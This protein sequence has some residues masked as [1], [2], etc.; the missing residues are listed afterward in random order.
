MDRFFVI[1]FKKSSLKNSQ[2]LHI[3][4]NNLETIKTGLNVDI[5]MLI[6]PG[7]V[8]ILQVPFSQRFW[9]IFCNFAVMV[10]AES[11]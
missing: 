8:E 3:W 4:S 10:I 6:V 2:N 1:F 11:P 7:I 9:L 5:T